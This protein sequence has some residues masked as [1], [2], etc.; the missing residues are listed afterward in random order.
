[1][2]DLQFRYLMNL[3]G[4]GGN[5][6]SRF[7]GGGGTFPPGGGAGSNF[8]NVEQPFGQVGPGFTDDLGHPMHPLSGNYPTEMTDRNLIHPFDNV[9]AQD[10][11]MVYDPDIGLP[12]GF[13]TG[14]G[15][16]GGDQKI[17]D[18]QSL[19]D[20]ISSLRGSSPSS[21]PNPPPNEEMNPYTPY[22]APPGV[23]TYELPSGFP[24]GLAPDE[25]FNPNT[26]P[27]AGMETI[28][29]QGNGAGGEWPPLPP[30][31][32][33][34]APDVPQQYPT[35]SEFQGDTPLYGSNPSGYEP[36][37]FDMFS[38]IYGG[39]GGGNITADQLGNVPSDL[40]G[41]VSADQ[42]ANPP[43]V[44][45]GGDFQWPFYVD[46]FPTPGGITYDDTGNAPTSGGGVSP[47]A[48]SDPNAYAP[49]ANMIPG[50][51]MPNAP[52][53]VNA[54]PSGGMLDS[55]GNVIPGTD[56][57]AGDQANIYNM[58]RFPQGVSHGVGNVV[59]DA[60]G[61][62]ID[63]T[64]KIL[65]QAADLVGKLPGQVADLMGR[66]S[67]NIM[68]NPGYS[69]QDYL[70][71]IGYQ[72]G[73][74]TGSLWPGGSV[75]YRNDTPE[76]RSDMINNLGFAG[77]MEGSNTGGVGGQG[78]SF[79]GGTLAP[80]AL[81]TAIGFG[82]NLGGGGPV[83]A[84]A[85]G[86][87]RGLPPIALQELMRLYK[88]LYTTRDQWASRI[89]KYPAPAL[90]RAAMSIPGATQVG[91]NQFHQGQVGLHNL[92][93]S[94]P[95]YFQTLIGRYQKGGQAGAVGPPTKLSQH[96]PALHPA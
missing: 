52:G 67:D 87:G 92:F 5:Q 21:L 9:A 90:T 60:A 62:I 88:G 44:S 55:S 63:A 56:L 16:L 82:G 95:S 79:F 68:N 15:G 81:S 3:Y 8:S 71:S 1:M 65:V 94:N 4:G 26:V 38:D 33:F 35:P 58:E 49:T 20:L 74:G 32:N 41:N 50:A 76:A 19:Q 36:M 69:S 18:E 83:N 17:Y 28:A 70:R 11:R 22:G 6:G 54:Y 39:G 66:I 53:F 7:S 93:Q 80:H 57:S 64:G 47:S 25:L 43:G 86:G 96:T 61:N 10:P 30:D 48:Y 89:S 24:G 59:K 12:L 13:G 73:Q 23:P 42:L 29:Y 34:A 85:L 75:G 37:P 27:D 72:P 77:P 51:G 31:L 78:G 46:Q 14:F 40:P 2:T 91:Y 84:A 45:G